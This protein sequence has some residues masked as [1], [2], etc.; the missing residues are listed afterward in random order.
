M[1]VLVWKHADEHLEV[2]DGAMDVYLTHA[3]AGRVRV[4]GLMNGDAPADATFA[5]TKEHQLLLHTMSPSLPTLDAGDDEKK[6]LLWMHAEEASNV[7]VL[8]SKNEHLGRLLLVLLSSVLL[9]SQDSELSFE[10]LRWIADLPTQFKLRSNQDEA[11]VMKDLASVLPRFV[12]VARN[13]KV[14]WLANPGSATKKTPTEYFDGLFALESGFSEAVM[15]SNAFKTY[16][17]TFFP[18]RDCMMISRAVEASAGIELTYDLSRDVLRPDYVVAADKVHS[19]YLS[20]EAGEDT[21]PAK[22]VAGNAI[23]PAQFRILVEYFVESLNTHQLPILQHAATKMLRVTCEQGIARAAEQYTQTF[24]SLVPLASEESATIPS[25]RLLLWPTLGVYTLSQQI[26]VTNAAAQTLLQGQIT[27]LLATLDAAY[28]KAL[29]SATELSQETCTA[30]LATLHPLSLTETT[31]ELAQRPRDEFPDGLQATLL[32]FKSNLQRALAEYKAGATARNH[33]G[34]SSSAYDPE[35]GLGVAMYP[36]LQVYLSDHILG[37]VVEWGKQVLGL[38]EKHMAAANEEKATLEQELAELTAADALTDTS[39]RRKEFER[40]LSARTEELSS[41]K[42]T[43]TAELEDKRMDLERL[44]LDLQGVTSKHEARVASTEREIERIKAKTLRIEEQALLERQKREALVHG[45]AMD[46][47]NI[48]TSL[49]SQQ[50]SLYSEQRSALAKVAEL[51]RSLNAKKTAHL[52][53]LFDLETGC[54]RQMEETK[55]AHKKDMADLKTQAK[56]DIFMLK[57]AYDSKKSVVQHQLD[58][59]NVLVKQCEDQLA[60]LEP[61]LNLDGPVPRLNT[62]QGNPRSTQDEMCKQS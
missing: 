35:A 55:A 8:A 32:G 22:Q 50:K 21:L 57:K 4:V 12:W 18:T 33:Q 15:Q 59:V 45:A 24:A 36:S 3:A 27:T 10:K 23:T 5:S 62:A 26:P 44:L 1:Q 48:E 56:Q 7:I 28:A 43:L 53:S 49:H 51:E 37:S 19:R 11:G 9:Y 14:K 54:A 52:Q 2:D 47:L 40:E 41:L 13:S 39:D 29:A 34:S 31:T 30:L 60:L 61:K 6:S 46:I 58:E 38:F 17:T 25:S 20:G 42:S 16:F